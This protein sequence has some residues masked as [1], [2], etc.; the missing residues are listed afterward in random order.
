MRALKELHLADCS[1]GD[2]GTKAILE[3]LDEANIALEV[4]DLSGNLIG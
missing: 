1:V 4:L 3:K 2:R